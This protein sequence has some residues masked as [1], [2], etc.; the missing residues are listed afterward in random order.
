MGA[1]DSSDFEAGG[2][3]RRRKLTLIVATELKL[4]RIVYVVFSNKLT[5]V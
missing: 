4:Y 3:D 5:S 1:R 2:L